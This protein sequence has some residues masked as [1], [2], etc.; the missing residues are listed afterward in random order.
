MTGGSG[1]LIGSERFCGREVLGEVI[2]PPMEARISLGEL[3]PRLE[4]EQARGFKQVGAP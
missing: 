4:R 3:T 2:G 1:W